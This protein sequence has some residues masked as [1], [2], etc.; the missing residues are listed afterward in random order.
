MGA[1]LA[2]LLVRIGGPFLDAIL[3]I[4]KQGAL[5]RVAAWTTL[6]GL[7]VGLCAAVRAL[8]LGITYVMP[9]WFAIGLSWVIPDN[10]TT[11]LGT[12]LAACTLITLYRWKRRG[13][14]LSLGI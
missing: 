2:S 6:V 7:F 5:R 1:A 12:Y 8:V 11:C 10:F 3:N 4:F 14:Q 13:I 9:D